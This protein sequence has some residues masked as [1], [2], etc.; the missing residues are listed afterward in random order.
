MRYGLCH[1]LV[2]WVVAVVV[3]CLVTVVVVI[4]ITVVFEIVV[5]DVQQVFQLAAVTS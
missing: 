1:G 5:V 4:I 3:I 2:G